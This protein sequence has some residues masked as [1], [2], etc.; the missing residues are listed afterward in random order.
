MKLWLKMIISLVLGVAV[1]LVMGPS[2]VYLKPI[3]SIFLGLLNMLVVLLVFS[4]MTVGVTSINDMK[5]LGRVGLKTLVMII[6]TTTLSI[7]IGICFAKLFHPGT[8]LHLVK[9]EIKLSIDESSGN[10]GDILLS[11]IPQ[12][13]MGSFASGHILPIIV[14]SIIL[15]IA[16]NLSGEKG[17]PLAR[18]LEALSNVMFT[19]TNMVMKLAPIGIFAIMAWVAGSFGLKVLIPLCKLLLAHYLA[20]MVFMVVG[21]GGILLFGAKLNPLPFFKGMGEA[22]ALGA[23][24][25]SS[26]A[27]LP[28]TIHC[29]QE[30]VGVSKKIAS[31]VLPLGCT[32]NKNG[33]DIFLAIASIFIAQAYGIELGIK[34]LVVIVVTTTLAAIGTGGI[35]GGSLVTLSIVLSSVGLPIEGIAIIAGIDRIRDIIGTVVNILGDAVVAVFVAKTE[36]ELD[37]KRY[38]SGQIVNYKDKEAVIK[39]VVT[40]E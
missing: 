39:E 8:G 21:I 16:I 34:E 27:T 35:P 24:T 17:K 4:S 37:M 25:T 40:E 33:T 11:L 29:T 15:G 28:C 36:G 23:S 38:H 32:I 22:I 19:M 14:F 13:P 2:A 9:E 6:V 26:S 3:G 1:G 10:L 12:N 7:V 20:C 31:F 5:M 18:A 30:N